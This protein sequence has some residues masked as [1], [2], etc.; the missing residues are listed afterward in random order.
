MNIHHSMPL[1]KLSIYAAVVFAFFVCATRLSTVPVGS[2]TDAPEPR[3]KNGKK[4]L[5][6]LDLMK[7]ANVTAPRLSPDGS[8][9]AYLVSEVKMEKDKEWK[10]VGQV[11][12]KPVSGGDAH[13]FTRGE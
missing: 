7:V 8:R 3:A 1:K 11:W 13:Q 2:A 10:T 12:V 4:L 5:T 6:A 9:V